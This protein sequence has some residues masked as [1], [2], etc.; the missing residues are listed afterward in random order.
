MELRGA[1]ALPETAADEGLVDEVVVKAATPET[2]HAHAKAVESFMVVSF[3]EA[4]TSSVAVSRCGF[5][6]RLMMGRGGCWLARGGFLLLPSHSRR[7]FSVD[8]RVV[9][10]I[11]LYISTPKK[12]STRPELAA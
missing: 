7:S 9:V 10:V 12:G 2:A 5:G 11:S 6:V 1:K 8:L 4:I 3:F